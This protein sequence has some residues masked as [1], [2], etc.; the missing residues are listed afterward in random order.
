MVLPFLLVFFLLF[1]GCADE[2]SEEVFDS[3]KLSSVTEAGSGNSK[4]NEAVFD[5]SEDRKSVV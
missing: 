1:S 4:E 5:L 2:T 3:E